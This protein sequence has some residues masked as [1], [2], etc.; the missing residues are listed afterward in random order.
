[1]A[2]GTINLLTSTSKLA[3]RITWSSKANTSSNSSSVTLKFQVKRTD[4]Y[5]TTGTW[6]A[7]YRVTRSDGTELIART[8]ATSYTDVS[9][10]WVTI[11]TLS[12]TATHNSSGKRTLTVYGEILAPTGTNLDGHYL[13]IDDLGGGRN[14][15]LDTIP[16]AASITSASN[17]NDEGKPTVKYSNPAGSAATVQV[18]L[19]WDSSTALIPYTTVTGTSG[20]ADT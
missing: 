10:S 13:V 3:G 1:M 4:S 2:S 12:F 14:I 16:R 19:Y 18:G 17:F 7:R 6:T 9:S 11:K 8:N 20:I 5:T 15:T